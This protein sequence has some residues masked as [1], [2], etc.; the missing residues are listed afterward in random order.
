MKRFFTVLA[1]AALALVAVNAWAAGPQ[2]KAAAKSLTVKGEIVDMGCY[3]AHGA[4]GADHQGCASKCIA[5]GM[6]FGLLTSSGKLYLLTLN[7]DNPDPYNQCKDMAAKMVQVT[8]TLA[9]RSGYT[10]IDVSGVKAVQ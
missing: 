10:A 6:P 4:H 8:G 9:E 7:H 3:L 2:S 1:L 5:S